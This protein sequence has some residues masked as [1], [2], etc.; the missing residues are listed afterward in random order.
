MHD[1]EG[2]FQPNAGNMYRDRVFGVLETHDARVNIAFDAARVTL[3]REAG[4][5]R[6]SGKV[7]L[8]EKTSMVTLLVTQYRM[9]EAH[10]DKS[11]PVTEPQG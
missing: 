4:V 8:G 2:F 9:V 1:V 7:W 5:L 11:C 3:P 6:V 10:A